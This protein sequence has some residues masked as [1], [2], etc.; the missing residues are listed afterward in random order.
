MNSLELKTK[1]QQFIL[2]TFEKEVKPKIEKWLRE[3]GYVKWESSM[4]GYAFYKENGVIL[5]DEDFRDSK[6]KEDVQFYKEYLES[7]CY[8]SKAKIQSS[9]YGICQL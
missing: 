2:D 1:V 7:I 9:L 6:N 3:H 5:V 8:Q 4:G